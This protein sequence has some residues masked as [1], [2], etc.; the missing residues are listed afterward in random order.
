[1]ASSSDCHH[2]SWFHSQEQNKNDGK[3]VVLLTGAS[4]FLGRHLL[5]G[6]LATGQ[7]VV[8][9]VRN[10][11]ALHDRNA[12]IRYVAADFTRD[13]DEAAWLPKLHGVDIVINAVGII[14]ER[15]NQTFDAIHTK[16]PCALFSACKQAGIRRVIQISALGADDAAQ[17][18]YHLSK[19]AADDFLA[20]LDVPS[21]IVQPSLIY[22][23][24]GTSARLFTMMA[25]MP[26]I[27]LPSLGEQ[28]IQPLH[29]DDMVDVVLAILD[30]SLPP[31][32]RLPAAGQRGLSLSEFLQILRAS[33]GM[34]R[35]IFL[36]IPLALMRIAARA[37]RF[38]P[39]SLLDDETFQML[40]RGNTTQDESAAALLHRPMKAPEDFIKPS[41]AAAVR[42]R[43]QLGWLLPVMRFSIAI[44][45]LV[46][47]I[48]SA[49]VFPVADSYAL[50]SR[51]G[52]TG[53]VAP[54]M[55]YG[56]ALLDLLFGFATLLMKRRHWLWVAQVTVIILY[57]G[58]ITWKLPE[59]WTH[60]YG[61]I[62][63]N[64]PMLASI[65]MLMELEA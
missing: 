56:A 7:Q 4:G 22:G 17:S 40:V 53:S 27:F 39:G 57:T 12:Q 55:L 50:L 10:P 19:K 59:F 49:A 38:L 31:G 29:I 16:A 42:Q 41:N 14:R 43:A 35:P 3:M 26:V 52:I 6:L 36:P 33:M 58:I 51:T 20:A 8:C 25:S 60:P 9:A 21:V 13:L 44:V 64:I 15:R 2:A 48:V 23:D 61:P 34:K 30:T 47:G 63:K 5:A 62:L 1:M 46:T 28:R 18:R 54:L 11:H 24:D 32:T 37:G 45:W 65:W